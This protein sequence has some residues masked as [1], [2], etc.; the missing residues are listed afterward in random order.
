MYRLAPGDYVLLDKEI[1]VKAVQRR[2]AGNSSLVVSRREMGKLQ[3]G[4]NGEKYKCGVDHLEFNKRQSGSVAKVPSSYIPPEK[5][6]MLR[7]PTKAHDRVIKDATAGCPVNPLQ[8]T[9]AVVA[10]CNYVKTLG[11]R[12]KARKNILSDMNLVSGIFSKTYNID[13]TI[14]SVELLDKCDEGD[15]FNVLCKDYPGMDAALN[16]FSKWRD[17]RNG[18]AG[19][20][21]LVSRRF[22]IYG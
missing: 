12:A 11:G 6:K 20:Y 5:G 17:G 22:F 2:A 14:N 4:P 9:V 16:R 7:V 3:E 13:I 19:I 15:S 21:H 18:D 8:L 10:D 1:A